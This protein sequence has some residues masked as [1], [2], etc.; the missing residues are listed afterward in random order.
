[1]NDKTIAAMLNKLSA[2]YGP[3]SWWESQNLV[4]DL[5]SMVLIQRTTERN[6]RLALA[7]I[8]ENIR[9]QQLVEMPL[10]ELQEAIRPA[11]FFQQKSRTIHSLAKWL[12]AY[13]NHLDVLHQLDTEEL[14]QELL[15]IKGIGFETADVILLYIFKRKVF[16]ADQ[17]AIRL[18]SRLGLGQY[19]DYEDMR[20]ACQHLVQYVSQEQCREWHA[21]IDEHG[22]AF[23]KAKGQLDESWLL[24]DLERF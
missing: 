9:L 3:Q 15:A 13:Q 16:I 19:T 22:K 1:M 7:N 23:R 17:Y 14:R 24:S 18:F 12:L 11:G 6:A 8:S 10:E 2:H 21:V 4:Q 20:K 5:L